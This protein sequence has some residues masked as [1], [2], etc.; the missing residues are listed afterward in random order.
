MS[1]PSSVSPKPESST[2]LVLKK[3]EPIP[4]AKET[5]L[6]SGPVKATPTV[7][8]KKATKEHL[9]LKPETTPTSSTE[10]I[11]AEATSVSP[12]ENDSQNTVLVSTP[13]TNLASVPSLKMTEPQA[14]EPNVDIPTAVKA[15]DIDANTTKHPKIE[16]SKLT[17]AETHDTATESVTV[18]PS[19]L[20]AKA[21]LAGTVQSTEKH[22]LSTHDSITKEAQSGDYI[23]ETQTTKPSQ[24]VEVQL[25]LQEPHLEAKPVTTVARRDSSSEKAA[26]VGI[27][28]SEEITM[29][30]KV[31]IYYFIDSIFFFAKSKKKNNNHTVST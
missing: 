28:S 29:S 5:P 8:S 1:Q 16:E 11:N 25:S 12:A 21:D 22:T 20:V 17:S 18:P 6:I 27:I 9:S 4:V 15:E 2:T 31:R 23:K 3:T 7:P 19:T 10:E 30:I 26:D 24:Q 14:E 13:E